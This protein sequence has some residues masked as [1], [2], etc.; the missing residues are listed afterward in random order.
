MHR[1]VVLASV[2]SLSLG[3]LILAAPVVADADPALSAKVVV[4]Q[5]VDALPPNPVCWQTLQLTVPSNSQVPPTGNHTH[6]LSI[7][8]QTDGV[9][10]ITFLNAASV[11]LNPGQWALTADSQPHAHVNSGATPFTSLSS[12]LLSGALC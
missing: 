9:Q 11:T 2:L 6:R 5:R 4:N 7:F 10:T 12:V 8:Y 3:V 1:P